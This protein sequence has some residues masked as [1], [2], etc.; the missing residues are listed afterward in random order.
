[1][2]IKRPRIECHFLILKTDNPDI[3]SIITRADYVMNTI[4][5]YKTDGVKINASEWFDGEIAEKIHRRDK[6]HQIKS[7]KSHGDEKIYKE[8]QFEI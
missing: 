7:E 5:P 3:V 1:M 2:F 4:A 6:L 8:A